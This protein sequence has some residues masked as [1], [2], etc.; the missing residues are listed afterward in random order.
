M[1][2]RAKFKVISIELYESPKGSARV[3]LTPVHSSMVD[4]KWV[5]NSENKSFWEATPQGELWMFITN[6][7]AVK[8]FEPGKEFYLGFTPA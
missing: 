4:G 7:E 5:E 6:P 3:K 2:V 8:Q 1:S